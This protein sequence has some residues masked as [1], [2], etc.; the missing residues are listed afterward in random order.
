MSQCGH[1]TTVVGG[2]HMGRQQWEMRRE[3]NAEAVLW[4]VLKGLSE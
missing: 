4:R 3:G 2:A 1:Q